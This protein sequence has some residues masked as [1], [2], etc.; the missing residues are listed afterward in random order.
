MGPSKKFTAFSLQVK[1]YGNEH[2]EVGVYDEAITSY[3]YSEWKSISSLALLNS[4][5]N[6]IITAGLL[7]GSLLCAYYVSVGK[8]TVSQFDI[9]P[10]VWQSLSGR[11][12]VKL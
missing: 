10:F 1:Y 8:L 2:F 4:A 5:Q 6:V 3:Q 7:A 11:A 9:T 12:S